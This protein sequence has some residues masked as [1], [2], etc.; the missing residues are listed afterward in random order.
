MGPTPIIDGSIPVWAQDTMWAK[1]V[2]PLLAASDFF[3]TITAAAPSPRPVEWQTSC[4][5]LSGFM[6]FTVSPLPACLSSQSRQNNHKSFTGLGQSFFS[7]QPSLTSGT[8]TSNGW[9]IY[10]A[11]NGTRLWF[12]LRKQEVEE[13]RHDLKKE[14]IRFIMQ[15]LEEVA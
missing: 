4:M 9:H 3:I 14:H 6:A 11:V 13:L 7:D 5:Y 10:T 15:A 2:R 8:N 1:G 12:L